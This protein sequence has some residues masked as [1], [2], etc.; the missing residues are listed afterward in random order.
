MSPVV[1]PPESIYIGRKNTLQAFRNSTITVAIIVNHS[2]GKV[3]ARVLQLGINPNLRASFAVLLLS[4]K[5]IIAYWVQLSLTT[6]KK[7]AQADSSTESQQ[8]SHTILLFI[9]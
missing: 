1:L 5:T 2:F 4:F 8:Q 3:Q 9:E 7:S 6:N